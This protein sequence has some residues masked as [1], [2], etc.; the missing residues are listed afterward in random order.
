M[1]TMLDYKI[2]KKTTNITLKNEYLSVTQTKYFWLFIPFDVTL[3]L[4]SKDGWCIIF[5]MDGDDD[6]YVFVKRKRVTHG[7]LVP[8]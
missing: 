1:L 3:N 7:V 4:M 6:K 5:P 2:E 8:S